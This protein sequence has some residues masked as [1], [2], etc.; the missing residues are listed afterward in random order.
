MK[1]CSLH[2]Q[3]NFNS[4]SLSQTGILLGFSSFQ[5]FRSRTFG[6][7]SVWALAFRANGN[8]GV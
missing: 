8:L 1:Q 4:S 6:N 2:S 5:L 3:Q 7:R